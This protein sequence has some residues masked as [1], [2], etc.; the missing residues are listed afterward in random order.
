VQ[1]DL[2]KNIPCGTSGGT[3]VY[4]DRIE[5]VNK[6]RRNMVYETIKNYTS[7][8]DKFWIYN[9]I[10]HEINQFCSK[11]TLQEIY[12]DLFDNLDEELIKS[13]QYDLNTWA[14]GIE[15]ISIRIT[16]PRIPERIRANFEQMEQTKVEYMITTE[17]QKVNPIS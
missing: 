17:R 16:K 2:V 8:Y 14:P 11:H 7:G 9:K 10:H 15:I 4:F 1:T 12:I 5:V 6:L 3:L 13:L